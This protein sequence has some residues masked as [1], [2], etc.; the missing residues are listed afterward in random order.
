MNNQKRAKIIP[1][2]I[3]TILT[4]TL[5]IADGHVESALDSGETA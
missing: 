1:I 5:A 3:F 4:P 2:F